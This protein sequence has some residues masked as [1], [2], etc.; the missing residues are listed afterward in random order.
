V[1]VVVPASAGCSKIV[2]AILDTA[3]AAVVVDTSRYSFVDF[4]DSA[5]KALL[6]K[7]KKL[8]KRYQHDTTVVNPVSES[9]TLRLHILTLFRDSTALYADMTSELPK[10]LV[11]EELIE[12]HW[13]WRLE[14]WQDSLR[15][16]P[17]DEDWLTDA[18]DSGLVRTRAERQEDNYV[19]T[20]DTNELQQLLAQI[21]R[22]TSAFDVHYGRTFRRWRE[23]PRHK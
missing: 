4:P 10:G 19:L 21:E 2:F 23:P 3:V 17:L 7:D 14:V 16:V 12:T 22:D 15:L 13:L 9:D 8:R 18:I 20:G 11:G 6:R 1:W 5:Q